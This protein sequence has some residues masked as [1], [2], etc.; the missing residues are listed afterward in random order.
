MNIQSK[1]SQLIYSDYGRLLN[2]NQIKQNEKKSQTIQPLCDITNIFS[3]VWNCGLFCL[4]TPH[5][6]KK[7]QILGKTNE[8]K[9]KAITLCLLF[10]A[11]IIHFGS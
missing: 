8:K 6:T 5:K 1:E 10:F 7:H 11:P 4:A 3:D 2:E 9:K